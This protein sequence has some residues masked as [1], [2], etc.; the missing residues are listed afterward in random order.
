MTRLHLGLALL[1]LVGCESDTG[2]FTVTV[3]GSFI[4]IA[5]SD[6]P[7]IQCG[8]CADDPHIPCPPPGHFTACSA[9]FAIGTTVNL[10]I[11]AQSVYSGAGCTSDPMVPVVPSAG[12]M[13]M[14]TQDTTVTLG[15]AEAFR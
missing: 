15:G 6:P 14:V 8:S 7:G 3:K 11:T 5:V 2:P 10:F 12:C 9:S 1:G 4:G 13:F